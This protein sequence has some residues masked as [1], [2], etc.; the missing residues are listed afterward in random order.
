[1]S[2]MKKPTEKPINARPEKPVSKISFVCFETKMQLN[3]FMVEVG[4]SR[5][6]TKLGKDCSLNT[7]ERKEKKV[8]V[9]HSFCFSILVQANILTGFRICIL[10]DVV[11]DYNKTR[12]GVIT[13]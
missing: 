12:G 11:Q 6:P 9:S 7:V 2:T 8:E 5:I 3:Y 4:Y 1:M 10:G 13:R